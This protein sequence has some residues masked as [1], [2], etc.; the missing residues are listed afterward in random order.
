MTS[1]LSDEE[2]R[3]VEELKSR[4]MSL[5]LPRKLEKLFNSVMCYPSWASSSK[6]VDAVWKAIE[7]PEYGKADNNESAVIFAFKGIAYGVRHVKSNRVGATTYAFLK[8][9]EVVFEIEGSSELRSDEIDA[10]TVFKFRE[11][12]AYKPGG[13]EDDFVALHDGVWEF[14]EQRRNLREGKD[15]DS[16][17]KNFDL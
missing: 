8:A 16:I 11:V 17:R 13:W 5:D 6:N 2:T 9:N 10:W 12:V 7:K 3:R 14:E 15:P 1:E 4:A